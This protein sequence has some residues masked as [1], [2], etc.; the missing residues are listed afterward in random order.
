MIIKRMIN[1]IKFDFNVWSNFRQN[2]NITIPRW[3]KA[4][5]VGYLLFPIN[6]LN[7]V[8]SND[9]LE[10]QSPHVPTTNPFTFR[11]EPAHS[12]SPWTAPKTHSPCAQ[13]WLINLPPE[14]P[15]NRVSHVHSGN[16]VLYPA[17]VFILWKLVISV[18]EYGFTNSCDVVSR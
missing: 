7:D 16:V 2:T 1:I 14:F 8:S 17:H 12:I 13:T 9:T 10:T 4:E 6:I 5:L 3:K 15:M 11:T 18:Y